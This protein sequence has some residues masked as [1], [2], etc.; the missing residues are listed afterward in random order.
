MVLKNR[1]RKGELRK[2]RDWREER[3]GQER[4]EEDGKEEGEGERGRVD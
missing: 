2:R 3:T 4:G 1:E